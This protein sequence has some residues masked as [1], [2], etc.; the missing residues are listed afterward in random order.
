MQ[1][2]WFRMQKVWFRM[3]KVWISFWNPYKHWGS[4]ALK[5]VLKITKNL[6]VKKEQKND[7]FLPLFLI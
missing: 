3:Q 4:Q 2:V 6:K 7:V 1:K 5:K